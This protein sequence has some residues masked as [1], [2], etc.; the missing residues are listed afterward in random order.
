MVVRILFGRGLRVQRK[1]GKNR[2]AALALGSLLTPAAVMAS[3]L[4]VWRLA[5]DIKIAGAFAISKGVFSHWQ[6]WM[7]CAFVLQRCA[8]MLNRYGRGHDQAPS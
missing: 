8:W 7:A 6:V 1:K 4:G 3:A 2:R 5:S